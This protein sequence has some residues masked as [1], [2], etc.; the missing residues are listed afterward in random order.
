MRVMVMVKATRQSEAGKMPSTELLAAMGNFNEELVKAGVLLAV[1]GLH[2]SARGKRGPFTFSRT[3]LP[4]GFIRHAY[5]CCSGPAE[6]AVPGRDLGR[7]RCDV[8]L[9]TR[10]LV[11]RLREHIE[12]P[13]ERLEVSV[14]AGRG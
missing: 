14:H 1:E 2:P 6:R 11:E 8:G 12:Q 13:V 3:R 7:R 10:S 5:R 4:A 9:E